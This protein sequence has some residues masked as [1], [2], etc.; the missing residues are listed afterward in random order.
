MSKNYAV[1]FSGG[2]SPY[3]NFSRYYNSTK[4]NY[5]ALIKRGLKPE[6]IT[7]AFADGVEINSN[8]SS[9]IC[10]KLFYTQYNFI[11]FV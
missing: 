11:L 9:D 6:N 10:V 8:F 4:S 7:I 2:G 3:D 5:E 1:L